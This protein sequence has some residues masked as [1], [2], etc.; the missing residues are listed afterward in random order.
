MAAYLFLKPHFQSCLWNWCKIFLE[1]P[2]IAP[3]LVRG[4]QQ[5]THGQHGRFGWSAFPL[6]AFSHTWGPAAHLWPMKGMVIHD[7]TA[8][9]QPLEPREHMSSEQQRLYDHQRE[10]FSR[11]CREFTDL[12]KITGSQRI[13]EKGVSIFPKV[14][15]SPVFHDIS[16]QIYDGIR[17]AQGR[18]FIHSF[19]HSLIFPILPDYLF[20]LASGSIEIAMNNTDEQYIVTALTIWHIVGTQ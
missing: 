4:W 3:V 12:H 17:G 18:S 6:V 8:F 16:N 10:F 19:I 2:Q 11:D 9:F 5:D 13:T 1:K 20:V 7:V 15:E 14:T